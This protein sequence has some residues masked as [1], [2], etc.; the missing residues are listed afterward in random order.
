MPRSMH[1]SHRAELRLRLPGC[2]PRPGALLAGR[3]PREEGTESPV[4]DVRDRAQEVKGCRQHRDKNALNAAPY[5]LDCLEILID[6]IR[7]GPGRRPERQE[8]S[9]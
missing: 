8:E 7:R 5:C 1:G 6:E 2:L 3:D 9:R 4:K